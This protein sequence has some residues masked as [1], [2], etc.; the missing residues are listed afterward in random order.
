MAPLARR[1]IAVAALALAPRAANAQERR[2]DEDLTFRAGRIEA[3]VPMKDMTLERDVVVTYGRYRLRSERLHLAVTPG[4]VLVEGE[5]RVAFCP[6]PDPPLAI[7][8][9]GGRVAPPGDLVVRFPRLEVFGVPVLALPW[10]WLRSPDKVGLLPPS[11]AW[12]G[13]DGLVAGAGVHLPWHGPDGSARA[14]DLRGAGYVEG[15]GAVDARVNTEA[16]TAHLAWDEIHG[17]RVLADAR[18]SIV[19]DA[20]GD[21]AVAWDVDA[22][23]GDRARSGTIDL[24]AASLPHDALDAETSARVAGASGG[25]TSLLLATGVLGRADRG[26]GLVSAGPKA[27]AALGGALGRAG[28][29]EA[30]GAGFVAS[31]SGGGNAEVARGALGAELDARP[32]PFDLRAGALGRARVA[33]AGEGDAIARDVVAAGRLEA[34]LP[35]VRVFPSQAEAPLAHWIIPVVEGRFAAGASGGPSLR[36]ILDE[37]PNTSWTAGGGLSTSLGRFAGSAATLDLRAGALGRRARTVR[38]VARARIE[39]TDEWI[40]LSGE[41]GAVGTRPEAWVALP[42]PGDPPGA[43][44]G[45]AALGRVRLGRE[46]GLRLRVDAAAQ[47]GTGAKMARSIADGSAASLPGEELDYLARGGISGGAD[48]T[49]PWTSALST[50]VRADADLEAGELLGLRGGLGYHHPCGCLAID[51]GGA[52]RVGRGGVD[53]WLTIDLAPPLRPESSP[54]R[55]GG[56]R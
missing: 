9:S 6:C 7:A 42:G 55:S 12:R 29:W 31:R 24:G 48:L 23:R 22:I 45:A 56:G 2:L 1:G 30:S 26:E 10:I 33:D 27:F 54:S 13:D 41:A 38:P 52:R 5:G 36:R 44:N 16:T 49:V 53:V 28:T 4:G 39:A 3:D 47:G 46:T 43:E 37:I 50:I 19:A 32:G 11:V 40:G 35:L 14:L 17:R 25:G 20:T 51:G 34:R 21:V 8:F 18:G 15:G